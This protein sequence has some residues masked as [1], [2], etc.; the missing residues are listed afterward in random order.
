MSDRRIVLQNLDKGAEDH[1]YLMAFP[2]KKRVGL[3]ATMPFQPA[4]SGIYWSWY[5]WQL[6]H[7]FIDISNRLKSVTELVATEGGAKE[8]SK[9]SMRGYH[10]WFVMQCA[11]LSGDKP[12][13]A[14]ACKHVAGSGGR[15][16]QYYNSLAGMLKAR[17]EGDQKE[18]ERQ[19]KFSLKYKEDG[20]HPTPSR[21]LQ[22]AFVERD[23]AALDREVTKGAKRYWKDSFI[24]KAIVKDEPGELVIDPLQRHFHYQWAYPEAAIAKLAILDGATITHDDVWFPLEFVKGFTNSSAKK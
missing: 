2:K 8:A 12:T 6:H 4:H 5:E 9:L 15:S 14:L 21:A 11:I 19:L 3:L 7:N 20:V 23:Y 18:A 16:Q 22:K 10:E 1:L 13:M 17:F 24:G